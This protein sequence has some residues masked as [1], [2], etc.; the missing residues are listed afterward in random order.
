MR[1]LTLAHDLF[2]SLRGGP[3][4][5]VWTGPNGLYLELR[6]GTM[7]TI[8]GNQPAKSLYRGISSLHRELQRYGRLW[9]DAG[10]PGLKEGR[11]ANQGAFR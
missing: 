4:K 5:E 2:T 8:P 10:A 9:I 7:V 1:V 6:G 11:I 3:V